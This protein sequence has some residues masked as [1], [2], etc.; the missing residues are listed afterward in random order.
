MADLKQLLDSTAAREKLRAIPGVERIGF[1]LKEQAGEVLPEYVFRVYVRLKKPI[2]EVH[3]DEIIPTEVDGIKTDVVVL[4]DNQPGCDTVIAPGMEITREALNSLEGSGTLGCVVTKGPTTFILTN[5]HVIGSSG[6][7][8]IYQPSHSTCAGISC[9]SP[10][11]TVVGSEAP[12][13]F[14]EVR[15]LDG[16]SYWIDCGLLQINDGVKRWNMIEGIGAVSAAIRDLASEPGTPAGSPGTVAPSST[17]TL[18]KR[19]AST[20]VTHG[21]VVEFCHEETREGS[22]VIL[23]ELVILP[24]AGHSYSETYKIHADEPIPIADIL[25]SYTGEPVSATLVTPGDASDRRIRFEG[26]V[27]VMKGDS[28]ALCVDDTH[29]ACGLLHI[30]YGLNLLIEGGKQIFVPSGRGGACHIRPVFVALGLN[31]ATSMVVSASPTSGAI[32]VS[33]GDALTAGI[34]AGAGLTRE[35]ARFETRL[36]TT[37]E[38]RRILSIFTDHHRELINL[39][40]HRRRVTVTWQR[41]KGPAFV[42]AFLNAVRAADAELPTVVAGYSL[43]VLLE[44]MLG[45]LAQEGSDR[46]KQ[47]IAEAGEF[48]TQL[49]GRHGTLEQLLDRLEEE[50]FAG[51]RAEL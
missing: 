27:F 20:K 39:V 8:D 43:Q 19:G 24:T 32:V 21:T 25:S 11:A 34:Q 2:D 33:P 15:V 47:A 1:G 51:A 17:I 13:A 10:V 49:A 50:A 30:A 3:P 41:N 16:K 44:K 31:P 26:T 18:H 28:G 9:N 22:L 12:W 4:L 48:L 14:R 23:W 46:L 5:A 38:G 7:N 37:P 45:V 35:L 42:A 36:Q 6:S 40:N 29:Q